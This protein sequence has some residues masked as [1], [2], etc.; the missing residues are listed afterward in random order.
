MKKSAMTATVW[1]ASVLFFLWFTAELS[2]RYL[3][4]GQVTDYGY[5]KAVSLNASL[6]ICH[7]LSTLFPMTK[8]YSAHSQAPDLRA[9]YLPEPNS[10]YVKDNQTMCFTFNHAE[11][12][13]YT[14][15]T[16]H[17]PVP[18]YVGLHDGQYLHNGDLE[19]R[20][21][22]AALQLMYR[23]YRT[24][25]LKPSCHDYLDSR[26]SCRQSCASKYYG[27]HVSQ[28]HHRKY[29]VSS[30]HRCNTT[31]DNICS[32]KCAKLDCKETTFVLESLGFTKDH[33]ITRNPYTVVVSKLPKLNTLI[34]YKLQVSLEVYILTAISL[35]AISFGIS[36]MST[37][38]QFIVKLKSMNLS[39]AAKVSSSL[40][41]SGAF[42]LQMTQI[43]MTYSEYYI[44]TETNVGSPRSLRYPTLLLCD[45][46]RRGIANIQKQ[47][48]DGDT[49]LFFGNH[50][51]MK[52][53]DT[54]EGQ[55]LRLYTLLVY[56]CW[57][58]YPK[59]E[60]YQPTDI[61]LYSVYSDIDLKVA[62]ISIAPHGSSSLENLQ[63]SFMESV[64][65]EIKSISRLPAPYPAN[66][67]NFNRQQ[68]NRNCYNAQESE[69]SCSTFRY[70]QPLETAVRCGAD[71]LERIGKHCRTMCEMNRECHSLYYV[72]KP[73]ATTE[74]R[75]ISSDALRARKL[76]FL[77]V[78]PPMIQLSN[79]EVPYMTLTSF[80]I[81]ISGLIGLWFGGN[82][83]TM[84]K[85]A[86]R[87]LEWRHINKL[88]TSIVCIVT[89]T[90]CTVE[91]IAY[92]KYDVITLTVYERKPVI[93]APRLDI[94]YFLKH[95]IEG[96][97]SAF[98]LNQRY[99]D[100]I[101]NQIV[102]A[103]LQSRQQLSYNTRN[104]SLL[105][106]HQ[107]IDSRGKSLFL[108]PRQDM[109]VSRSLSLMTPAYRL[110]AL[111][112][113]S[114]F[115]IG[116]RYQIASQFAGSGFDTRPNYLQLVNGTAQTVFQT[117]HSQLLPPPYPTMCYTY[118]DYS[119]SCMNGCLRNISYRLEKQIHESAQTGIHDMRKMSFNKSK[120]HDH[121]AKTCFE[122]CKRRNCIVIAYQAQI[123]QAGT[124]RK[125]VVEVFLDDLVS[126]ST[127][128][129][130]VTLYDHISNQLGLLGLW[131]GFSI[132]GLTVLSHSV[133]K[134]SGIHSPRP[135]WPVQPRTAWD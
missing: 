103:D 18:Y 39:L 129:P 102:I 91:L 92:C 46:E 60:I 5:D 131:L 2:S 134:L 32:S 98:E 111:S 87:R 121:I 51:T 133:E 22:Y 86:V 6:S 9:L 105:K 123:R 130:L 7:E 109:L 1:G 116:S 15:S 107:M 36:V 8:E 78:L 132:L 48:L 101:L 45:L 10:Y 67:R 54:F 118:P 117:I 69:L 75:C 120:N 135:I 34:E 64:T 29:V 20:Q 27:Y 119:E 59:K 33:N 11:E 58:I 65:Y 68:C 72:T 25:R 97:L 128:Y 49:S 31:I 77:D 94:R 44:S 28:C 114:T 66:C 89:L 79:T 96:Q 40:L 100:E 122:I 106:W 70:A 19:V 76:K 108:E 84:R 127:F 85:I 38:T 57:R 3:A 126:S 95:A 55:F 124:P 83:Q 115:T 50:T 125:D 113:N 43:S 16:N 61:V 47:D 41:I 112:V 110:F 52:L 37:L 14:S 13:K 21:V 12:L 62:I 73:T 53:S 80:V 42:L 63:L 4:R 23:A 30:S 99:P 71:Q 56:K 88:I 24:V 74:A 93:Y 26:L 82:F 81:Y 35:F 17:S 90:H 104:M